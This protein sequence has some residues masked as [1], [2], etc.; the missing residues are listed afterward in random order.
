MSNDTS[1]DME[2]KYDDMIMNKRPEERIRDSLMML[3]LAKKMI[4]ASIN[5]NQNVRQELFLRL[6]G[7]DFDEANKKKI[8]EHLN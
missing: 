8:L 2:K 7:D 3:E 5:Q 4:I 1:I 6:Y